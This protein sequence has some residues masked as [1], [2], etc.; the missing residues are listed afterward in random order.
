MSDVTPF[1]RP[2]ARLIL[3]DSTGRI[4]LFRV[5]GSSI[6]DPADPRGDQQDQIFWI[7][8]GGGVEPGESFEDAARREL[9]EETGI[10]NAVLGPCIFKRDKL[11]QHQGRDILFQEHYFC[12]YAQIPSVD[13]TAMGEAELAFHLDSRWWPRDELISSGEPYF[14]EEITELMDEAHRLRS[15]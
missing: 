10:V 4:L 3:L 8:P 15:C 11:L 1:I 7:T 12:A 14:P 6:F 2:S 9:F 13:V 5:D